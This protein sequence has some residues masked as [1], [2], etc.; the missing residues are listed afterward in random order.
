MFFRKLI[1][2]TVCLIIPALSHAQDNIRYWTTN[3]NF[4]EIDV[5]KLNDRLD[6]IGLSLPIAMT[7]EVSVK[8]KVSVPLNALTDSTKYRIE[9]TAK[10]QQLTLEQLVLDQFQADI[11]LRDGVMIVD[12]IQAV[13]KTAENQNSTLANSDSGGSLKGAAR[14]EISP[15]GKISAELNANSV[16]IKPLHDLILA[17]SNN[18][19]LPISGTAT[20][21]IKWNAPVDEIRDLSQWQATANLWIDQLVRGEHVPLDVVTSEMTISKG[22]LR[23]DN[24]KVTS[25]QAKEL[26]AFVRGEVELAGR[27]R[28]A[29]AIRADDLPLGAIAGIAGIPETQFASGMMDLDATAS[30]EL[31]AMQWKVKG[32]VASPNLN[33]VGF[34]LGLVEHSIEFDQRHFLVQPI[35]RTERAADSLAI[36]RISAEY[37]LKESQIVLSDIA[38][39]VFGGTVSGEAA[40]DRN[41]AHPSHVDLQWSGLNP[42]FNANLFSLAN[43]EIT[44][45]SSGKVDWKIPAGQWDQPA[46]QSGTAT[47]GLSSIQVG[48]SNVG[49]I[50]V[51]LN[52]QSGDFQ[53]SASGTL[54]GGEV[55]ITTT[56]S[57]SG[58]A[59]WQD[60]LT[61]PDG[62]DPGDLDLS[63]DGVQ[64][65]ALVNAIPKRVH[66][67]DPW[68]QLRG[69]VNVRSRLRGSRAGGFESEFSAQLSSLSIGDIVL[70]RELQLKGSTKDGMLTLADALGSYA[71]GRLSARGRWRLDGGDGLMD[72]QVAAID[73]RKSLFLISETVANQVE[74][75]LSAQLHLVGSEDS[76]RIR[77]AVQASDAVVAGFPLGDTHS[78]VIGSYSLGHGAWSAEFPAVVGTVAG[79]RFTGDAHLRSSY[80]ASRFALQS[81]WSFNRVDFA[82]LM[83]QAGGSQSSIASG[84]A[85]GE[86]VLEGDSI[87]GI[88]D[89]RGS[90]KTELDG[91]ESYAIPGLK[92]AQRF[93]GAI[94]LAGIRVEEGRMNGTIAGGRA[95]IE[96]FV[97]RSPQLRLWAEGSVL[98]SNQRMD[99]EAVVSTGNFRS[100]QLVDAYLQTVAISYVEP[101]AILIRVNRLLSNRTIY[102]DVN[103]TLS[104]PTLRLKPLA[105]LRDEVARYV[106]SELLGINCSLLGGAGASS[107]PL[108]QDR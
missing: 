108:D 36:D 99:L 96:E 43:V 8:L 91:T 49:A 85:K 47:V 10:S 13:M 40:I 46:N 74:G 101:I 78:G 51:Q 65:E 97:I 105:T 88:S 94:P 7:G 56:R 11:R 104:D 37:E 6:K 76:I 84:Q 60:I 38:A 3:W 19:Q 5:A 29:L 30:G 55:T 44:A 20:G 77:G 53:L 28:F 54:F 16:P 59:S 22:V 86:L 48:S 69:R 1:I 42:T 67:I 14:I 95:R 71:G 27:N 15:L 31:S 23:A 9:G 93:L 81:K 90:F 33:V 57:V 24:L 26:L 2:V 106:L 41:G 52:N 89:L 87:A 68:R 80:R 82:E 83:L 102:V 21:M 75:K 4:E 58:A 63:A 66:S 39:N 32:R 98:L 35:T 17:F 45:K 64:I 73:A 34:D 61:P 18:D 70:T 50:N 103:G 62:L 100:N 25:A 107:N 79:G 12:E 72:V 92:E